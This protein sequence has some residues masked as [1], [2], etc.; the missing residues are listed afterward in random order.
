MSISLEV[1]NGENLA[2]I[3]K[4]FPGAEVHTLITR[5]PCDCWRVVIPD[6]PRPPGITHQVEWEDDQGNRFV[7]NADW[8]TACVLFDVFKNSTGFEVVQRKLPEL[9]PQL[10]Q[11]QES[12]RVSSRTDDEEDPGPVHLAR[13]KREDGKKVW[14]LFDRLI[15][16]RGEPGESKKKLLERWEASAG[17]P[18]RIVDRGRI[19]ET[20][21]QNAIE[22]LKHQHPDC[23]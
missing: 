6:Q 19:G 17:T 23:D 7:V 16:V 20:G 5:P 3:V 12:G 14:V 9:P 2:A 15:C 21:L 4:A 13:V 11:P 1:K 10:W 22:R 8:E 18:G